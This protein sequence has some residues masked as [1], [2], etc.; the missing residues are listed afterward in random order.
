MIFS[1]DGTP[2]VAYG[3][4]GGATIINSVLNV[5][6]NL[7]DHRMSL[8][9]AINAPRVSVTSTAS[10]IARDNGIAPA[11]GLAAA[12]VA[13]LTAPWVTPSAPPPTSARYRRYWW[14][15]GRASNTARRMHGA[16]AR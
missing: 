1:P 8:Q 3:S 12:T 14:T 4:P 5:T 15:K 11:T 13:G 6:L 9:D 2:L 16:R 10:T 7:I